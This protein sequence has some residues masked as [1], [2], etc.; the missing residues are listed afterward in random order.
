MLVGARTD[1]PRHPTP[2]AGMTTPRLSVGHIHTHTVQLSTRI[3]SN[4]H[5]WKLR[6]VGVCGK[7]LMAVDVRLFVSD[8]CW[9]VSGY[10]HACHQR[11]H[12]SR[13]S[14]R[15]RRQCELIKWASGRA[16]VRDDVLLC[17]RP[18]K[19]NDVLA[20]LAKRPPT[21]THK[22]LMYVQVS[23]LWR[24]RQGSAPAAA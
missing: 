8:T 17:W 22:Q 7:L 13:S 18:A 15:C 14:S 2:V 1:Y 6:H 10:L 3:N 19:C 12:D 11:R 24:R 4:T 5:T 21:H 20:P 16:E 9:C 23:A